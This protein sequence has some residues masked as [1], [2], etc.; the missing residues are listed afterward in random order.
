MNLDLAPCPDL[1]KDA[2]QE[3]GPSLNQLAV[4]GWGNREN[5]V[6]PAL[7]DLE[8]YYNTPI[9]KIGDPGT[10]IGWADQPYRTDSSEREF[11][12]RER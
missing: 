12:T 4:R 10:Q 9:I 7:P 8:A 5:E 3:D 6:T 11:I 1:A 2:A